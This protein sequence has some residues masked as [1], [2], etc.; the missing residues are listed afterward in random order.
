MR[1][2]AFLTVG[3]MPR[4]LNTLLS[5]YPF[6]LAFMNERNSPTLLNSARRSSSPWLVSPQPNATL[7]IDSV[8]CCV[9]RRTDFYLAIVE[10]Q[11]DTPAIGQYLFSKMVLKEVRTIEAGLNAVLGERSISISILQMTLTAQRLLTQSRQGRVSPFSR[12]V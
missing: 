4:R 8:I 11:Q 9:A 5:H 10:A 7:K 1:V 6:S 2:G 3:L 12:R